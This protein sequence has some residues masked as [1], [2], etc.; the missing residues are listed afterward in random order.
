MH[1]KYHQNSNRIRR[2]ILFP[3]PPRDPAFITNRNSNIWVFPFKFTNHFNSTYSQMFIKLI[4]EYF[5]PFSQ[6]I[7][8]SQY[9]RFKSMCSQYLELST[10]W[11]FTTYLFSLL[12]MILTKPSLNYLHIQTNGHRD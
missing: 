2:L 8:N 4:F 9:S 12:L 7:F 6:T 10:A 11:I 3:F 1:R 5:F